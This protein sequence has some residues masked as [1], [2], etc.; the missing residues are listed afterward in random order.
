MVPLS[1]WGFVWLGKHSL[2]KVDMVTF[3]VMGLMSRLEMAIIKSLKFPHGDQSYFQ[4]FNGKGQN[5]DLG[6]VCPG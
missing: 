5:Y 6:D 4:C 2:N 1:I 3:C